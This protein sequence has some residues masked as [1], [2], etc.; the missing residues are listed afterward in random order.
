MKKNTHFKILVLFIILNL[1]FIAWGQDPNQAKR[2]LGVPYEHYLEQLE[3]HLEEGEQSEL[4]GGKSVI[5][6]ATYYRGSNSVGSAPSWS[7]YSE[8]L[9]EFKRVRDLKILRTG[10]KFPRRIFWYYPDDGCFVRAALINRTSLLAGKKTPGKVFAF[11]N[12]RMQTKNSPRGIVGWW[13]HVASIVQV[14][15]T[16]YVFDPAME[17]SRPVTLDEWLSRMGNPQNIKVAVC[18]SGA[19]VPGSL[20]GTVSRG[21]SYSINHASIYLDREWSRILQL[22]RNPNTDLGKSPPWYRN[23]K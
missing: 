13:Y 7:S 1:P 23:S 17:I 2:E 3:K 15:G 8:V 20:C 16:K 18:N 22:K 11:G 9:K 14:G 19:Y 12:L 21:E 6:T 10:T 5:N 4:E